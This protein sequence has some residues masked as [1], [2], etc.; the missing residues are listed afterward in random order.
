MRRL[1]PLAALLSLSAHAAPALT[2]EE[3]VRLEVLPGWDTAEGTHMAALRLRLAPGWKTY[4]RAP[5]DAGIPPL[6]DWSG[7][8]NV[9]AAEVHWP[10]PDVFE[11]NG[12]RSIGYAGD[13]VLPLELTP[14]R[15]GE[16]IRLQGVIDIGVCHDICV[17]AQLAFTAELPRPGARNGAI[18]A[19]LVDRPLSGA[20]AGLTAHSCRVRP[21]AE[22]LDVTAT[23]AL[24][25][26]GPAED[27]VIEVGDPG[28]WV[29]EPDARREGGALVAEA[30]VRGAAMLDRSAMTITVLAGG[31]AVQIDG[32]PAG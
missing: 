13:V 3:L 20:E 23:L 6:F 1:I 31:S 21:S 5:G 12:M 11:Q 9:A 16:A 19:A 30:E 26:V 4:W 8:A 27:V 24:P 28:A 22:G 29:S 14:A 18:V 17:P 15:P 2:P 25:P 32:C 7:S 10:V